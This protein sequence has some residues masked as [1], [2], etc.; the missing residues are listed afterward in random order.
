MAT[1]TNWNGSLVL[2]A[3]GYTETELPVALPAEGEELINFLTA[4][5][6]A[7]AYSSFSENG[8][9]IK[10]GAQQTKQLLGLFKSKFGIPQ[11]IYISGASMGGLIAIK[12]IEDHPEFFDGAL[13]LC[14]VSGGTRALYD[15]FANT[16]VLFDYFYPDVLPGNAGDA[17]SDPASVNTIGLLAV[18]AML[19]DPVGAFSIANVTQTPVPFADAQEL[20]ESLTFAVA[21]NAASYDGFFSRLHNMPYFDNQDTVYTGLLPP[22]LLTDINTN[23]DRFSASPSALNYMEKHFQPTGKLPIPMISLFTSRDPWVPGFNQAMYSDLVNTAGHGDLLVQRSIERYG[24]CVFTP[25][26][27]ATAF[28]DIFA[29]V[30]FGIK[31]TP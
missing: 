4:Q 11:K 7:V 20:F 15:Y 10:E 1:P 8:W 27:I 26:E 23:V 17:P 29:W 18:A 31:P 5:G 22:F 3:H 2:Y 30:E 13:T 14:P 6:F 21:S 28:F 25:E 16:R 9:V 12:L 24:H 19:N